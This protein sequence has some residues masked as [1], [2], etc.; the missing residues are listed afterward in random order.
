MPITRM[1]MMTMA[2]KTNEATS[3]KVQ[4]NQKPVTEQMV[5][6]QEMNKTIQHNSRQTVRKADAQNPEYRYDAKEKGNNQYDGKQKKKSKKD[7]EEKVKNNKYGHIS[8][9]HLDITI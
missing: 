6:S 2:P 8:E 5:M 7:N 9:H 3:Y 4:Q 1:D